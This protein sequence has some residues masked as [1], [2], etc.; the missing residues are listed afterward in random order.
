MSNVRKTGSSEPTNPLVYDA[1]R[2]RAARAAHAA[3]EATPDS[4]GF[5]ERARELAKASAAVREAPE[6]RTEKVKE[7]RARI[8]SGNYH[9]DAREIARKMLETGF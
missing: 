8:R 7:L 2:L 5:S 4:A 9:P 6:V 1:A 3:P